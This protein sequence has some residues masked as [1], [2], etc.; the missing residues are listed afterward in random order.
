MAIK[1]RDFQKLSSTVQEFLLKLPDE[2][3][4][5]RLR[6]NLLHSLHFLQLYYRVLQNRDKNTDAL[7]WTIDH[8]LSPLTP[9]REAPDKFEWDWIGVESQK[10]RASFPKMS[11]ES[12][13]SLP[14]FIAAIRD[15]DLEAVRVH[16]RADPK[17]LNTT[18]LFTRD[19]LTY[20]VQFDRYDVLRFLLEAGANVN[21]VA[22]GIIY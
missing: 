15:G 2:E 7:Q 1:R 3:T 13:K 6:D 22:S 20:A 4:S 14:A 10:V 17:C 11:G 19:C 16:V 12:L 5:A 21:H 9:F 8:S 18:D